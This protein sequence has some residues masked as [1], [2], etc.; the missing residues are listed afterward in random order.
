MTTGRLFISKKNTLRPERP[1]HLTSR[2]LRTLI[3]NQ[4]A[5]SRLPGV[6]TQPA[7]SKLSGCNQTQYPHLRMQ[8]E[9]K[10][11]PTRIS[12][13]NQMQY[14]RLQIQPDAA[15][16]P[17][18]ET[19]CSTYTLERNQIQHLHFQKRS[20]LLYHRRVPPLQLSDLGHN[21][22]TSSRFFN[23]LNYKYI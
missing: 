10:P 18:G 14:R 23:L 22:Y 3:A 8:P 21:L 15:P 7:L 12:G 5:T 6:R 1:E 2:M 4:D 17:A 20:E 19:R 13:R 16:T 9:S 11:P